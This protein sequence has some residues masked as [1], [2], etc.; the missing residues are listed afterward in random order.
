[1]AAG[2]DSWQWV[3]L[4]LITVSAILGVYA[5]MRVIVSQHEQMSA[6]GGFCFASPFTGIG[7]IIFGGLAAAICGFFDLLI[8]WLL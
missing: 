7:A 4:L 3:Q 8:G 6:T 2:L 5:E 1:M